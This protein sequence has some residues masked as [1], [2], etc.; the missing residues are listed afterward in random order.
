MPSSSLNSTIETG[1]PGVFDD[2]ARSAVG[3]PRPDVP[4]AAP[5]SAAVVV[6]LGGGFGR[7]GHG[8]NGTRGS[9]R[10]DENVEMNPIDDYLARLP[11]PQRTTLA[12]LRARILE[13]VPGA[14]QT[15]AYGAP[16]F[17]VGGKTF[18]GFAAFKTHLSYLPH[19]GSVLDSIDTEEYET[20]KGALKFPLDAPL[21][22][23]LIR[24][25][26]TARMAELSLSPSV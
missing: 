11:E 15:L 14:E 17:K 3:V 8:R 24:R 6:A 22:P 5:R 10:F 25:L 9:T 21:S 1:Q 26:V 2:G 23:D 4:V 7:V 20:S 18:A 12:V 16:A 13:V 19:S